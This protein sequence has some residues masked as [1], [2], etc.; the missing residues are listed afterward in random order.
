MDDIKIHKI[1]R[2][3]RKTMALIINPDATLTVKVPYLIPKFFVD[4]FIKEKHDWI[5]AKI[6]EISGR[7]QPTVKKFI[8]GEKF[9]YLGKLYP[10]KTDKS[11]SIEL[12]ES[13]HLPFN[14]PKIMRKKLIQWYKDKNLET[15]TSRVQKYSK[16]MDVQFKEISL[17]NAKRQWGSCSHSNNL[18]FSWRLVMAPLSVIDYVVIHELAHTIQK[19]HSAKFW[20]IIAKYCPDY[21]LWKN[22]LKLNGNSLN[23]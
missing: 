13:L 21:K 3:R 9:L 11:L 20:A 4:R 10:L 22:W 5:I 19:N 6:K 16:I 17:S 8:D 1:I 18:T 14:T 7:P 23:T 12:K 15:V 2:Q